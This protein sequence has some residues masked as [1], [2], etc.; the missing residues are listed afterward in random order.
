MGLFDK[1]KR[2]DEKT[3][4]AYQDMLDDKKMSVR[5]DTKYV[6]ENYKNTFYIQVK[7]CDKE[8]AE[9]PNIEFLNKIVNLEE[10]T[11]KTLNKTFGNNIVFLG[12]AT[13][14]GS[15]YITFASDL[16]V[17]WEE[18]IKSMI[19]KN[20]LAGIYP[21]DYMGYYNQVLYPEFMRKSL[22]LM[23]A[24]SGGHSTLIVAGHTR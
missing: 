10:K 5:V 18:Y 7:Y 15:S 4:I 22:S 17:K 13:F 23:T 2:K 12:T 8:V 9:L 14:G 6:N 3:W 19:D 24:V 1:L 11:I 21:N 16:D 20:L